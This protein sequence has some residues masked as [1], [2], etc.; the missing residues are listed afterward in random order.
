MSDFNRV[1]LL[2]RIGNDLELK[3]SAQGKPYLKLSLATNFVRSGEEKTT[4]WHRVMVFGNQA[5]ICAT[6]LKKGSQV[7]IEGYL[8]ARTWQDGEGKKMSSTSV[9]ANRVQFLGGRQAADLE[10]VSEERLAAAG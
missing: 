5:E 4:H 2:G 1:I 9:I 10:P 7:M 6:Y 3:Q 8:E